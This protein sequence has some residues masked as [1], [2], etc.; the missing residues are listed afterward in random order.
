MKP[1]ED[2]KMFL[3]CLGKFWGPVMYYVQA[4]ARWPIVGE[5]IAG[6]VR[7]ED[8]YITPLSYEDSMRY[9]YRGENPEDER[10]IAYI[11]STEV[12]GSLGLMTYPLPERLR[13][14]FAS[15]GD[16]D[17]SRSAAIFD[18]I[19]QQLSQEMG[20]MNRITLRNIKELLRRPE[21]N[22]SSSQVQCPSVRDM[23]MTVRELL[24]MVPPDQWPR[25]GPD[26]SSPNPHCNQEVEAT[27]RHLRQHSDMFEDGLFHDPLIATLSGLI[28]WRV[29]MTDG[30]GYACPFLGAGC[31]CTCGTF[32]ELKVH[33]KDHPK[34]VRIYQKM[35]G[36]FWGPILWSYFTNHSWPV[37]GSLLNKRLPR[38]ISRV[39]PMDEESAESYWKRGTEEMEDVIRV[40]EEEEQEETGSGTRQERLMSPLLL[41]PSQS[42][43]EGSPQ[44]R[45]REE[46]Q[47][48]FGEMPPEIRRRVV[49]SQGL[50]IRMDQLRDVLTMVD[51]KDAAQNLERLLQSFA[52]NPDVPR[53]EGDLG[54]ND[55]VLLLMAQAKCERICRTELFCPFPNCHKA[56][57]SNA[58]L[59]T[60][61][62]RKHDLTNQCCKDLMHHFLFRLCPTEI[63]VTLRTPDG[64]AVDRRWDVERC[65]FLGCDYFQTSRSCVE[66]YVLTHGDLSENMKALGWF[67][68][69]M[70]TIL[71]TRPDATIA[72]TL[73]E[74]PVFE[75]GEPNCGRMFAKLRNLNQHCGAEHGRA[76]GSNSVRPSREFFQSIEYG[77][78]AEVRN[79]DQW[80]LE[81][82]NQE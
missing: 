33:V 55:P 29:N 61:L 17:R 70:R 3:A 63:Y 65:P 78:R 50:Q 25:P 23:N 10:E 47:L 39:S 80:R 28:G 58:N 12:R 67:W 44:V 76:I 45:P 18:T 9:W 1:D 60:H 20:M 59:L 11:P 27:D 41:L 81:E 24:T 2:Q 74:G 69:S 66:K 40:N 79:Q 71:R 16:E 30:S 49:V 32:E 31:N 53:L 52:G 13:L 36:I 37:I 7:R 6:R 48:L 15:A 26:L 8:S 72:D 68:G 46:D 38:A 82:A 43:R 19:E 75:C 62:N 42:S 73:G 35:L 57:R 5:V 77:R 34:N 4:R 56:I 22:V 21:S 51:V 54:P 14:H 64:A